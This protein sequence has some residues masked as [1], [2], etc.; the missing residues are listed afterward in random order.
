[1][2]RKLLWTRRAL[3]RLDQIGTYIAKH[4]PAAAAGSST[5]CPQ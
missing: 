2:K 5:G 1:M 4:N 3:A